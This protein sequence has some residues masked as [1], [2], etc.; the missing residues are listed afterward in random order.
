MAYGRQA[1]F[2]LHLRNLRQR[3]KLR[4]IRKLPKGH[5]ARRLLASQIKGTRQV[6]RAGL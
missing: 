1:I 2:P 3:A 4:A 5:K 6:I